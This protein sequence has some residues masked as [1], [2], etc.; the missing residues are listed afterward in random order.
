M[1][2]Q[3]KTDS[4]I[5]CCVVAAVIVDYMSVPHRTVELTYIALCERV[6]AI[7]MRN[8]I[9]YLTHSRRNI[10]CL[11]VI[12]CV[13]YSIVCCCFAITDAPI[14]NLNSNGIEFYLYTRTH[15][16]SVHKIRDGCITITVIII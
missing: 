2:F 14:S 13:N 10:G 1:G 6:C 8:C 5:L 15:G 3:A 12:N 16:C 4:L 9:C 7:F 11:K